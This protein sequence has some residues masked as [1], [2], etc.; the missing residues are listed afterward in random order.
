MCVQAY[1]GLYLMKV[2]D[3]VEGRELRKTEKYSI[4]ELEAEIN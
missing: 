3:R 4:P 2:E 1:V